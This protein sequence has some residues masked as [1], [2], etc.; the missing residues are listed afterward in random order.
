MPV[1]SEDLLDGDV[2]SIR[3]VVKHFEGDV[4]RAALKAADVR[5]V[6]VRSIRQGLQS[7]S[8]GLAKVTDPCSDELLDCGHVGDHFWN[9]G[10]MSPETMSLMRF[11]QVLFSWSSE[12]APPARPA[13]A[14]KLRVQRL[15]GPPEVPRSGSPGSLAGARHAPGVGLRRRAGPRRPGPG[16]GAGTWASRGLPGWAG[17]GRTWT[18]SWEPGLGGQAR[19]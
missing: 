17:V 3:H 5:V 15:R 16:P 18:G 8:L 14:R 10:L 13:V 4:P 2:E 12:G 11:H 9:K 7:P 19:Y 6:L 1:E